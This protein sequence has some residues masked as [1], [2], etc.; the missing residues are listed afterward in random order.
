VADEAP[1]VTTAVQRDDRG[2][3]WVDAAGDD[4]GGRPEARAH[5]EDPVARHVPA[6]Q[7]VV[8]L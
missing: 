1:D 8:D 2:G 6:G 4:H 5:E 3:P 7:E